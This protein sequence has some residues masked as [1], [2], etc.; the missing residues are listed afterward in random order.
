MRQ[1]SHASDAAGDGLL[2]QLLN[3]LDE[4]GAGHQAKVVAARCRPKRLNAVLVACQW[5]RHAVCG[6][7]ALVVQARC[8]SKTVERAEGAPE[9]PTAGVQAIITACT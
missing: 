8:C 1:K 3:E 9:A 4:P 5:C 7:L 2:D 6:I